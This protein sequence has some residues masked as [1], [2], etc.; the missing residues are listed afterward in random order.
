MPVARN[1]R[2][3]ASLVTVGQ[4]NR[5]AS[6][7]KERRFFMEAPSIREQ[8]AFLTAEQCAARLHMSRWTI[9]HSI[10]RGKLDTAKRLRPVDRRRLIDWEALKAAVEQTDL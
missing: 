6:R 5:R 4:R 7:S 10:N 3:Q 9:Y 1:D 8:P 2:E